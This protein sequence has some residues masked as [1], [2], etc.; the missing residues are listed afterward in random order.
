MSNS[1]NPPGRNAR[2]AQS[3]KITMKKLFITFSAIIMMAFSCEEKS[4]VQPIND[5]I[6]RVKSGQSF[7]MCMGKCYNELIV[8]NNSV[9]LKQIERKERGSDPQTIEHRDNTHWSRIKAELADFP[10]DKF[11][12]LNKEYGCPDCADGGAEWL[13]VQ[14]SDGTVKHVEFDYGSS[15]EGFEEIISSL[16][17]HRLSLMEKYR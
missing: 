6:I 9:V 2:L 14:F 10:K 11:L 15:V 5:H 13:E 7:G 4:S 12:R 3:T 16:R 1:I 8:E 17:A